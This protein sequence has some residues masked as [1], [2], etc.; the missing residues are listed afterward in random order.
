MKHEIL[1][2]LKSRVCITKHIKNETWFVVIVVTRDHVVR[3]WGSI[4]K[5]VI[6]LFS[7]LLFTAFKLV[8]LVLLLILAESIHHLLPLRCAE[9]NRYWI[10]F[11]LGHI[12]LTD[13]EEI[14][15]PS[16]NNY[17]SAHILMDLIKQVSSESPCKHPTINTCLSLSAGLNIFA[18]LTALTKLFF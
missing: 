18:L 14:T 11:E 9:K 17:I 3:I 5:T 1:H 16:F 8:Y 4:I 10:L 13:S 12:Q 7:F 6:L 15:P 2:F